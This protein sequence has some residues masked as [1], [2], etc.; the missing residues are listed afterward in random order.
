MKKSQ[1]SLEFMFTIAAI[2]LMFLVVL[3][4]SFEK[5]TEITNTKTY[6]A[7]QS[8]CFRFSNFISSVY[9][10]GEGTK[11]E[12]KTD[13]NIQVYP[14]NMIYVDNYAL[15]SYIGTSSYYDVTGNLIIINKNDK[16]VIENA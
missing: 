16:V 6:L 4:F 11:V 13:H 1:I 2:I 8:E 14:N 3:I 9:I 7:Q 12:L 5:N 10:G 15:C